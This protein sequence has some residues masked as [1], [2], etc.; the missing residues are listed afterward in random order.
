[1]R[2]RTLVVVM[3]VMDNR[4]KALRDNFDRLESQR[5]RLLVLW[6]NMKQK[7][8]KEMDL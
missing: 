8:F 3:S 1:M 4:I 7:N 5:D 6:K 2:D